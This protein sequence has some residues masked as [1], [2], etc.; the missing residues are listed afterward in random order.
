M[1]D[2]NERIRY[3]REQKNVTQ[4]QL[5]EAIG[6]KQNA[7]SQMERSGKRIPFP[8]IKAIAE[9]L[10]VDLQLILGEAPKYDL[11][12]AVPEPI[13]VAAPE[14]NNPFAQTEPKI[15]IGFKAEEFAVSNEEA[16]ILTLYRGL[17]PKARKEFLD[18][19]N[20]LK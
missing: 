3:Y 19:L 6:M 18:Y 4:K 14:V 16:Q 7:Y 2:I 15:S 11:T 1:N 17:K 10:G 8:R 5:C 12:P 13:T 9:Y 20:K